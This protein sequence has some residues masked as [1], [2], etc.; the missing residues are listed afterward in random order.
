MITQLRII[1]INLKRRRENDDRH[2]RLW[3][4][5]GGESDCGHTIFFATKKNLIKI[6]KITMNIIFKNKIKGGSIVAMSRQNDEIEEKYHQFRL[7][8]WVKA[9]RI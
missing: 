1:F 3:T 6:I 2:T 5:R 8:I 9:G 4:H 7:S